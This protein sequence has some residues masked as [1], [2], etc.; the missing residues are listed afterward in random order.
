MNKNW[1][2]IREQVLE[3]DKYICQTCLNVTERLAA[4][5]VI[6]R[7]KNG[8]DSLDNLTTVC[9]TCHGLIEIAKKFNN[10]PIETTV[11]RIYQSTKEKLETL[12]MGK[13]SYD[14]IINKL[15]EER[16]K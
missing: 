4:H 6:P 7:S 12:Y 2:K 5:H 15:I 9:N 14:E 8:S 13:F 11:I 16:K 1:H 3:R 10:E